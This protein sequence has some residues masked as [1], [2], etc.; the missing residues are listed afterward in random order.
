[1]ELLP[2]GGCYAKAVSSGISGVI[3]GGSGIG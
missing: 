2:I 3:F 1:M